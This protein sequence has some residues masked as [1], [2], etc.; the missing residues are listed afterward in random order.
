M[1]AA[2]SPF[3]A[4]SSDMPCARRAPAGRH[5]G[6]PPAACG[7]SPTGQ[8]S[9][10]RAV[11][12]RPARGSRHLRGLSAHHRW[13]RHPSALARPPRPQMRGAPAPGATP[14][15]RP[16]APWPSTARRLPPR[17][18]RGS[19]PAPQ[20]PSEGA[21]HLVPG[22][23]RRAPTGGHLDV[24]VRRAAHGLLRPVP[25]QLRGPGAGGRR[26]VVLQ[27]GPLLHLPAVAV[28]DPG[29]VAANHG[30]GEREQEAGDVALEGAAL[31]F[32]VEGV[33]VHAPRAVQEEVEQGAQGHEH[34]HG[35][36]E[37]EIALHVGGLVVVGAPQGEHRKRHR[38]EEEH[39]GRRVEEE[40][41][42]VHVP[43]G[44]RVA[45]DALVRGEEGVHGLDQADGRG[46][47]HHAA[48]ARHKDR[49]SHHTRAEA[50]AKHAARGGLDAVQAGLQAHE[51][52]GA[53]RA[54]GRG[55]RGREGG[56]VARRA[57]GGGGVGAAWGK[58]RLA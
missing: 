17:A 50:Q 6:G 51:E 16:R 2:Q 7:G 27:L 49:A 3:R 21:V 23:A 1:P 18:P 13:P 9:R 29:Q 12:K 43:E 5:A 15:A 8:P 33:R 36:V 32:R 28:C 14:R 39:N 11:P 25:R 35:H 48:R 19:Q 26:H 53:H 56:R 44:K 37:L 30:G 52:G 20:R 45:E 41:V 42:E 38:V 34:D 54:G 58:G 31:A 4:L 47:Q 55:G 57:C 10:P 22:V 24:H 40:E 46:D